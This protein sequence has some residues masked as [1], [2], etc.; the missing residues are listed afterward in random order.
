MKRENSQH[1]I[2][3][4]GQHT[5]PLALESQTKE[6]SKHK[7]DL[8]QPLQPAHTKGTLN[9]RASSLSYSYNGV[10]SILTKWDKVWTR[11]F[12]GMKSKKAANC[13]SNSP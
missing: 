8:A 6:R 13:A 10:S 9:S 11:F 1:T 2:S 7:Q 4:C 12:I 3:Q 5:V